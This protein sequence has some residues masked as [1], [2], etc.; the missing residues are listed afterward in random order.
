MI[1]FQS[2]N[3]DNKANKV[4]LVGPSV[5]LSLNNPFAYKAHG[6]FKDNQTSGPTSHSLLLDYKTLVDVIVSFCWI[7]AGNILR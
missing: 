1:E 5:W 3:R 7:S 2:N 4:W 6:L